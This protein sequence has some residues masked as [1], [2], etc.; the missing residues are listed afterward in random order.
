MDCLIKPFERAAVLTA[1]G[2]ARAWHDARPTSQPAEG[3]KDDLAKWLRNGRAHGGE[4]K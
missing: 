1:V 4:S 3:G 2:L